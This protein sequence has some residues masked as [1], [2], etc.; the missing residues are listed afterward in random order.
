MILLRGLCRK[1][2]TYKIPPITAR[3]PSPSV[4]NERQSCR[5]VVDNTGRRW[6]QAAKC[7][8]QST[9]D[10]QLLIIFIRHIC[11]KIA[12]K[13]GFVGRIFLCETDLY[14]TTLFRT[15]PSS[16]PP[17]MLSYDRLCICSAYNTAFCKSFKNLR[18]SSAV[19]TGGHLL[20]CCQV[21]T[22]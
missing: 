21:A 19:L 18:N 8:Q 12:I 2:W 11:W 7:Y 13:A 5:S 20:W 16:P 1:L 14:G 10:R 6:A 3:S 17:P 9:D 4:T 22:L 15:H